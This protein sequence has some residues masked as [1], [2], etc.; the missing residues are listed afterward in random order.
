M[1][2]RLCTDRIRISLAFVAAVIIL[3]TNR[4]WTQVLLISLGALAG[5]KLIRSEAPPETSEMF[6]R[7]PS[8]IHRL[9]QWRSLPF[10]RFSF[11][12]L[13]PANETDG[14]RYL[15][16]SIAP[17]RLFSVAAMLFS[18]FY[19]QKLCREV[20]C[21]TA[22]SWPDTASLRRCPVL[23]FLLPPMSGPPR[24]VLPTVV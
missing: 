10:A 22:P 12:F 2:T 24:A 7:L 17:D 14:C 20:G 3:L 6:T 21:T 1:A 19:R 9:V 13:P 18:R 15:T 5:W 8:R 23:C 4:S 16:V 11:L